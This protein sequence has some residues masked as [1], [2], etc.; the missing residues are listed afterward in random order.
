MNINLAL[1]VKLLLTKNQ[2]LL[3]QHQSARATPHK[4]DQAGNN[5]SNNKYLSSD[6]HQTM[7]EPVP[8]DEVNLEFT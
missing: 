2:Q 6:S 8:I 3:F 5:T 4:E 1:I 7:S